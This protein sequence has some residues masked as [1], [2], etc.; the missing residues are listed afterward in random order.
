MKKFLTILVLSILTVAFAS[1]SIEAKNIA[2]SL[3]ESTFFTVAYGPASFKKAATIASNL[4]KIGCKLQSTSS[5]QEYDMSG[6]LVKATKKVY[7]YS[8]STFTIVEYNGYP[9]YITIKFSSSSMAE[10]FKA[11]LNMEG[12]TYSTTGNGF[13]WYESLDG[14][15]MAGFDGRNVTLNSGY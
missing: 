8:G 3:K 13:E 7:G 14:G 9:L 6:K 5:Q 15:A 2:S 10:T 11:Q 1:E 12:W 4:T